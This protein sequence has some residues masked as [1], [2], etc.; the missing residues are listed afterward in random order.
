MPMFVPTEAVPVEVGECTVWIK[1]RM[2]LDVRNRV[3]D[4]AWQVEIGADGEAQM[5]RHLNQYNTALLVVNIE[6][7]EGPGLTGVPCTPE[8]IG[9][10]D[11][12]DSVAGRIIEAVL[13]RIQALN[14]VASSDPKPSAS[15]AT[16]STSAGA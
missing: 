2:G 8:T 14:T 15:G 6:R 1:P 7:W 9:R 16:G 10:L 4:V 5:T 11:P 3:R 13:K 12:T